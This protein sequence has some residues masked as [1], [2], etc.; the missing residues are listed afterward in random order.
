M[1]GDLLASPTASFVP[2][3]HAGNYC[4]KFHRLKLWILKNLNI[5]LCNRKYGLENKFK[6][7]KVL[8]SN[9]LADSSKIVSSCEDQVQDKS[10]S[11]GERRNVSLPEGSSTHNFS[12]R[13][14]PS[15]GSLKVMQTHYF[16]SSLREAEVLPL[17]IAVI[18]ATGDLSRTKIFPA[19][20]AL[21]YS[22]F[23]PENVRIFGYSSERLTDG[24]L[25]SL[26]ASTLTCRVDHQEN[27]GL[28]IDS[29]LGKTYYVDGGFDNQEGILKLS[30]KMEQIEGERGANRIFYLS[31]PQ[32]A[33]LDVAS[34]IADKSQ[35]RIG[36]NRIIIEKPFGYNALSSN[37]LTNSLL[38]KF[39]EKQIY[40]Y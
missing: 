35:T 28:K 40:R 5:R 4:H 15:D 6:P 38:L 2:C 39:E 14:T 34:C 33:V 32:E 36:W 10:D 18:G 7:S 13:V 20:F 26:I 23:L 3:G 27:C 17:S 1:A 31:V 29:F 37:M 9:L 30:V 24:D 11:L 25:R 12:P 22:G 19:L 16:G 8:D 21:Y